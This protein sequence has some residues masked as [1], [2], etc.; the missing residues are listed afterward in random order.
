MPGKRFA[1]GRGE[2]GMGVSVGVGEL[3]G[4]SQRPK[5]GGGVKSSGRGHWERGNF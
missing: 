5:R 2:R 4:A 3:V 1:R